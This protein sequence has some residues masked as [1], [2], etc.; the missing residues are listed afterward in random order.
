MVSQHLRLVLLRKV[1]TNLMPNFD[2]F[3][4]VKRRACRLILIDFLHRGV[5]R[6]W[7]FLICFLEL[8]EGYV[9]QEGAHDECVDQLVVAL[10]SDLLSLAELII[11]T[12]EPR[13]IFIINLLGFQLLHFILGFEFAFL[14]DLLLK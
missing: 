1:I 4:S 13:H 2:L 10:A 14:L 12:I 6:L 5:F 3:Q 11:E 9:F 8:I 7:G